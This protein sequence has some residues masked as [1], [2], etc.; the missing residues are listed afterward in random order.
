MASYTYIARDRAGETHEGVSEAMTRKE[1]MM[2]LK[3]KGL[4][5]VSIEERKGKEQKTG[6]N[7]RQKDIILFT[8]ELSELVNSGLPLEPALASME[9]RSEQGAIKEVASKLRASITDGVAFEAALRKVSDKF[10]ELYCNLMGAGEISGSLPSILKNHA[11]Y[12]K[13]QSEL[14]GK[15]IVTM[16]Y[17]AILMIAAIGVCAIFVFYLL[18]QISGLL[19]S[20]EGSDP[21]IGIEIAEMVSHFLRNFWY[22]PVLVIVVSAIGAKVW[23]MFEGNLYQRDRYSLQLPFLGRLINYNF[24]VQWLQTLSNLLQNGVNLIQALE[25]TQKTVRNRHLKQQ[26]D[27]LTAQVKDGIK[28][29]SGMRAANIFPVGMIDLIAVADQ[30]GRL[31]DAVGRAGD[32]YKR[33]LD[34]TMKWFISSFTILIIIGMALL[35]GVLCYTL[36]QAIYGTMNNMRG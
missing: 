33:K 25:L 32:Y 13:E 29:T 34:Y 9:S 11:A 23:L 15:L 22:I 24:Y 35:V 7:I 6:Y 5:P 18:P 3:Q 19:D 4:F 17:P 14:K 12:L 16:I 20:V 8:E 27:V 2:S 30:T 10:D 26:L 36:L 21:P 1:V 31:A 28:V